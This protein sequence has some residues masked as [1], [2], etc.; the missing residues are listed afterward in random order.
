VV[1][2]SAFAAAEI[3]TYAESDPAPSAAPLSKLKSVSQPVAMTIAAALDPLAHEGGAHRPWSHT[4][5]PCSELTSALVGVTREQAGRMMMVAVGAKKRATSSP[6]PTIDDAEMATTTLHTTPADVESVHVES[7]DGD[8]TSAQ[9]PSQP[10]PAQPPP[11]PPASP[12]FLTSEQP[13]PEPPPEPPIEAADRARIAKQIQSLAIDFAL[14]T[15]PTYV[16]PCPLRGGCA[17]R[18]RPLT[19]PVRCRV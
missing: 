11:S 18:W 8:N 3:T 9:P 7:F 13:P 5:E 6:M 1:T 19:R 14:A 10:V 16:L 12:P 4:H 15:D 17:K 2:Q